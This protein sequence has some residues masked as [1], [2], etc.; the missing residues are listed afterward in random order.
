M[1]SIILADDS[2]WAC[3]SDGEGIYRRI[4][5]GTWTQLTGTSQAG[6][7]GTA[8]E[9]SRY[10]HANYRN[11]EGEKLPRMTKSRGWK[12]VLIPLGKEFI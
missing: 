1:K 5:D 11:H 3:N 2:E 10:V 12:I 4:S 9:F 6:P 7:F 8:Q